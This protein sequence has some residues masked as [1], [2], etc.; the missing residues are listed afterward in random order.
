[1]NDS[2]PSE[3]WL[4]E[5]QEFMVVESSPPPKGLTDQISAKILSDLNPSPWKIFFKLGL[6]HTLVGSSTLLICPQFGVGPGMELMKYLMKLGPHVC[7]FGC[8]VLFLSVSI[9]VSVFVLRSEEIRAFRKTRLLQL[10]VLGLASMGVFLCFGAQI[11]AE[12][13]LVWI[14]GSVLGALGSFELGWILRERLR[15]QID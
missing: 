5:F 6:I 13:A 2:Q 7:M 8:G 14:L 9:L 3:K 12:L 15:E 4:H 1:M 11:I 10:P